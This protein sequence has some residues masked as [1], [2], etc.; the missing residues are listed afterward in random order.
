MAQYD[1]ELNLPITFFVGDQPDISGTI[2]KN[3]VGTASG[4]AT[5]LLGVTVRWRKGSGYM[6]TETATAYTSAS[7]K[8]TFSATSEATEDTG[9]I[10][11]RVYVDSTARATADAQ[12]EIVDSSA[13]VTVTQGTIPASGWCLIDSEWIE[14]TESGGTLTFVTR[15]AFNTTA[16]V[17]VISSVV[18]FTQI[19]ETANPPFEFAVKNDRL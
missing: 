15:G 1:V 10:L 19:R 4:V 6:Y 3:D 11:T 14:Y 13:A 17:H 2:T 18:S 12:I 9:H 16:A 8:F 7:G 5:N